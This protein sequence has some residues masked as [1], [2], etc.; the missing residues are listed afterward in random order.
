LQFHTP[1]AYFVCQHGAE[2]AIKSELCQPN[3]P[4]R[5]AFS[6]SGFVTLKGEMSVAPWSRAIPQSPWIR[7]SGHAH[8]SFQASTGEELVTQVLDSYLPLD[9]QHLH[10]WQ[11]DS[12]SPGWNGF[13]PGSNPL[14]QT[15]EEMI[16]QKLL[17]KGDPR[18]DA[19]GKIAS[20]GSRVLDVILVE[21]NRWWVG[22]HL[23][24]EVEHTWPGGVFPVA[25]PDSMISRAYL[26]A[27]EAIAWTG[28]PMAKGDAVVEIGSSPGG[29][30]QR[31]LELGFRVTGVDPAEMDSWLLKQ[32]HFT[33]W[34]AKSL[35]LKRRLFDPFPWLFCDANVAP[36]YTLDT[37][38]AIVT[39]PSNATRG[40]I[41]TMKLPEWDQVSHVDEW[42]G[43]V[44]S[45]GFE[46]VLAR[47]LAFSR[48]EFCLAALR[49]SWEKG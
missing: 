27:A 6:Q 42:I 41:L 37:V 43:R 22:S 31:L 1:F 18:S 17:E 15:V 20:I 25:S 48:Q 29:A 46:T 49:V 4:Y 44:R 12:A 39:Y 47:Q 45:W 16:R 30:C 21:P 40:V 10:V 14:V 26:K 33:H 3:G 38:E 5:L 19:V 32:K 13:E 34:R 2:P 7:T 36:N 8:A 35:Q 11:R 28:F 9:W 23:C 24:E